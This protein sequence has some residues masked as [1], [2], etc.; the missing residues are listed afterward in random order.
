MGQ[1]MDYAG[2]ATLRFSDGA[3]VEVDV[4]VVMTRSFFSQ[5]AEGQFHTDR[6]TADRAFQESDPLALELAD[7]RRT[8][9]NV[10]A[11]RI[12]SGG[13]RCLFVAM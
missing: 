1:Q 5:Y 2:P 8:H 7:G 6:D 9:I 13:G 10:R 3:A 4:R 11:A 12:S